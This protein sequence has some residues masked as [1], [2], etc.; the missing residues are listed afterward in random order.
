MRYIM[1]FFWGIIV[2]QMINYI[3]G[4]MTNVANLDFGMALVI[5]IVFSFLVIILGSMF[6]DD[7]VSSVGEHH[8]LQK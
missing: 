1:T 2:V 4:S 5:G 8:K 6:K 7:E 3:L